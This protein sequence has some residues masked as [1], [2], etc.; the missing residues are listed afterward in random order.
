ATVAGKTNMHELALGTTNRNPAFGTVG[1]PA[2]PGRSAGGSSGG[3]AAAVAAGLVPL[4]L[5][6]D[7]GGS[8]RIPASYCGIV[9]FRPSIGRWPRTGVMPLSTTRD[10]VG[11]LAGS[12]AEVSLVDSIMTGSSVAEPVTLQGVR[13]G[14]PHEG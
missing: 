13:L 14:V 3:S 4:A 5:G 12:V 1:N 11:V 2:A 10:T 8:V 7:T 6:T 9:G